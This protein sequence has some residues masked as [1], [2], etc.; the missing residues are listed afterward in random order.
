MIKTPLSEGTVH[1]PALVMM[2][3]PDHWATQSSEVLRSFATASKTFFFHAAG[4]TGSPDS[5]QRTRSPICA[6]GNIHELNFG[7]VSISAKNHTCRLEAS[8]LG[9]FQVGNN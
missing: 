2:G 1:G 9:W 4:P 7:V 5:P 3:F 8:E 6:L